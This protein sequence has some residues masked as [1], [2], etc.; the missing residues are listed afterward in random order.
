VKVAGSW[1]KRPTIY[2]AVLGP[3]GNI[4]KLA[5]WATDGGTANPTVLTKAIK[6]ANAPLSPACPS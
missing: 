1:V 5:D 3:D 6:Q 2:I 4:S